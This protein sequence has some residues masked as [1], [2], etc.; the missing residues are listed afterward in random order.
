[1]SVFLNYS[2]SELDRQ[3]DQRAWV[4]NAVEVIRR[5]ATASDKARALLGEP[6]S[7]A[8]GPSGAETLDLYRAART[9][10]PLHVF[11]HGGAWQRL[12]KRESAFAAPLFVGA[13]AHFA[14]L[15][16]G[17]VP[18]VTLSQMARQVRSAI[19]WLY[20]NAQT[21]GVDRERIY[22]SGHSSGA[23]LAALVATCDWGA[24]DLPPDVVK[25][26]LCASGT[27][28]L[29]AVRLSSRNDY[30]QLTT[31]TEQELSPQRHLDRLGC[32]LVVAIGGPETDEFKRQA[33]EFSAAAGVPLITEPALNHFEIVET[34][35]DANGCLGAAALG[36]MGLA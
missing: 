20:R 33:R 16:F 5:Y 9:P 11:I 12:S 34:L 27:Y 24:F 3:Y 13:G 8:Y 2:Q 4:A 26:A 25:G 30:L 1:M 10:A 35:A 6:Q 32:K 28:D 18:A 19:A 15:D 29:K 17:L 23:H 7:F 14:A 31:E 36:Q 22:V 21:I